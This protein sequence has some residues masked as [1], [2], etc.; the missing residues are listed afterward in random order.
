MSEIG[1]YLDTYS[2]YYWNDK[3]DGQF[4]TGFYTYY[5]ERPTTSTVQAYG[6]LNDGTEI[7]GPIWTWYY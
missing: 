7:K 5:N 1:F 2:K 6:I 3:E 4:T